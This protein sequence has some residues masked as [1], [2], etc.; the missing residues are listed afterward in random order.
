LAGG[1]PRVAPLRRRK[2]LTYHNQD[3]KAVSFP[4]KRGT[5]AA[6]GCSARRAKPA[7]RLLESRVQAEEVDVKIWGQTRCLGIETKRQQAA[8]LQA[9]RAYQRPL[10][11]R[12]RVRNHRDQRAFPCDGVAGDTSPPGVADSHYQGA[13][14][15]GQCPPGDFGSGYAGLRNMRARHNINCLVFADPVSTLVIAVY[16]A[17]IASSEVS[18]PAQ[19]KTRKV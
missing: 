14:E 19:T 13:W 4:R 7:P 6:M 18:V 17:L 8:A 15:P 1:A 12:Q 9:L 10:H 11:P 2:A 3:Q 16:R 5:L